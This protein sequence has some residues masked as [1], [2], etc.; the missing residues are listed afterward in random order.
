[1]ISA[2]N[3]KFNHGEAGEAY[4]RTI[5]VGLVFCALGDIFLQLEHSAKEIN[6]PWFVIGLV[7]FLIGHLC[8]NFAFMAVASGGKRGSTYGLLP[9][10]LWGLA[11]VIPCLYYLPPN[12]IELVIGIPVYAFAL[13]LMAQ[14]SLTIYMMTSKVQFPWYAFIG[15]LIFGVSDSILSLNKFVFKTERSGLF[16]APSLAVISTYFLAV[17]LISESA[18]HLQLKNK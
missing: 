1:M 2:L 11:I 6:M 15:S 4:G 9:F 3:A 13:L 16:N 5:S 10:I 18:S 12:K 8:F 7:S 17:Y 14:K